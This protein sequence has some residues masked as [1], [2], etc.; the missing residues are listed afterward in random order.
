MKTISQIIKLITPLYFIIGNFAFAEDVSQSIKIGILTDLSGPGAYYGMQTKAGAQLAE[1]ELN[2]ENLEL[3]FEDSRLDSKTAI[4]AVQKLIFV[5]K[6][7]A[8]FVDFTPVSIA[9][10]PIVKNQ[11]IPMIYAAAAESVVATNPYAFKTYSSYTQ[12]CFDLAQEFKNQGL[13]NVALLKIDL[14]PGELCHQAAIKVFPR[15]IIED[16]QKGEKVDS[17]IL[18]L[19]SQGAEAILNSAFEGDLLNM[20]HSA[21]NLKY[22]VKLASGTDS[23][24]NDVIQQMKNYP[25]FEGSL[26]FGLSTLDKK[27][28]EEAK[29]VSKTNILSGEHGVGLSYLH[30][31]QLHQAIKACPKKDQECI[32]EKI[33]SAPPYPK[34]GFEGWKD[35][36]A[37]LK[38]VLSVFDSKNGFVPKQSN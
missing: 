35:R 25:Y 9:V 38:L 36:I 17:Q 28:I 32:H 6:I 12:G 33:A 37:Q 1:K 15:L 23:F 3:I 26:G 22:K 14:E 21:T 16:Y 20:I 30:I 18:K 7:D 8:L 31:N 24:G 13:K 11:K 10:S 27:Q 34:I 4:S 5:D 19:K 2:D 29:K